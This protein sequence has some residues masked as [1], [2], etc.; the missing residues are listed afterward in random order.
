MEMH[1]L[2]RICLR[3]DDIPAEIFSIYLILY[4]R[5]KDAIPKWSGCRVGI[6]VSIYI[7]LT[8]IRDREQL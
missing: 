1:V 2:V 7:L 3:F 4:L 8:F 6:N 5:H